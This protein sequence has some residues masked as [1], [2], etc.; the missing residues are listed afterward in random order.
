MLFA[1]DLFMVGSKNFHLIIVSRY[2]GRCYL[3]FMFEKLLHQL[4]T[5]L[6]QYA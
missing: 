1:G 4:F 5:L 6:F 2:F 3:S